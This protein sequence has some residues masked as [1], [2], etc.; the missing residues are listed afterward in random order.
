MNRIALALA[1]VL[2]LYF[3]GR[4]LDAVWIGAGGGVMA[5][6]F[7]GTARTITEVDAWA[8]GASEPRDALTALAG[9][10]AITGEL[11]DEQPPEMG[12][13]AASGAHIMAGFSELVRGAAAL[14]VGFGTDVFIPDAVQGAA[15]MGAAS[16]EAG[17]A[18]GYVKIGKGFV[19]PV[20]HRPFFALLYFLI[21]V[22]AIAL[23]GGAICR[24]A[25]VQIT[26]DETLTLGAA[27]RFA[28]RRFADLVVAPLLPIGVIVVGAVI[29]GVGGLIGAIPAVGHILSALL[30]G[31]ALIG[32]FALALVLIGYVL[33][34]HLM[35]PTIGVEGSDSFD[36]ITRSY[37]YISQR[38]WNTLFYAL[39]LAVYG[40]L[41][42]VLV[43]AIAMV[44]LKLTHT[45]VG[46]GF[47]FFGMIK[48]G[49]P[50]T[51]KLQALW[52]MPEWNQL[53]LI[54]DPSSLPFWGAFEHTGLS[55][56]QAFAS[57]L[58]AVWVFLFVALVI[59]YLL[60]FYFCGCTQMYLLLRRDVD[61]TD[62][63]E[64][65]Y[66]ESAETVVPAEAEPVGSPL[67]VVGPEEA[68]PEKPQPEQPPGDGGSEEQ[69]DEEAGSDE[70]R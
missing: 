57:W 27:F 45:F 49:D 38:L 22:A 17:I 26:R 2:V 40:G 6:D 1:L 33:G 3:S 59:A 48:V 56:G 55:G 63:D 24:H 21:A 44:T 4:I 62:Y 41:A 35:W 31:L 65:F 69:S 68:E 60:S 30:F 70:Q 47:S 19:W 15:L 58:I 8:A 12:P 39:L 5:R 50:G 54:P 64:V 46:Y 53:P 28:S 9:I 36:A 14:N 32:G 37:G 23:F 43:R 11:D 61:A 7:E 10:G 34:V 20:I 67:P 16:A 18:G 52:Q 29:L 25:A 51:P 42:F 66:E 13:F